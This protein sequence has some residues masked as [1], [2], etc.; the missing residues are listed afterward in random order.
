MVT[1]DDST[2]YPPTVTLELQL[3]ANLA[4]FSHGCVSH[5]L[6]TGPMYSLC[7]SVF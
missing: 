6:F 7:A 4:P 3:L 5:H 1:P 2:L